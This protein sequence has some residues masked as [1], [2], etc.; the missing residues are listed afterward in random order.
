MNSSPSGWWDHPVWKTLDLTWGGVLL[1]ALAMLGALL[2]SRVIRLAL[3]GR[4]AAGTPDAGVR[5]SLSRILHYALVGLGILLALAFLGVDMGSL[6][7]V[8]GALGVGIGFGLQAIVGNFIAGLI[9]LFERP[10]R[11]GDRISLGTLDLDAQRQVN[12]YVRSIGLRSTTVVTP[13]NIA[14]IVPN[15]DLIT[16][17]VVNWSLGEPRMRLRLT[18]GVAYGSDPAQVRSVIERVAREQPETLRDPPAEVRLTA[19]AESALEFQLLVWIA[20]PRRRGIVES[21]LREGLVRAFAAEGI[22]IPFPQR[23]VRITRA[24]ATRG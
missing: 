7:L 24:P 12:G 14:L 10:I 6:A 15:T 13:D 17:T 19:T 9:L 21:A 3:V 20:D 22:A 2:I 4:R 5:Y 16:R 8:F 1:A 23:D 18:V 11:I